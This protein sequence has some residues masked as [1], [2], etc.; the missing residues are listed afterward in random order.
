MS[1]R[2]WRDQIKS[3]LSTTLRLNTE[4]VTRSTWFL[5][6]FGGKLLQQSQVDGIQSD[7]MECECFLVPRYCFRSQQVIDV[8][9]S[10]QWSQRSNATGWNIR[11]LTRICFI[12]KQNYDEYKLD[13]F[14]HHRQ[15]SSLH[16][17]AEKSPKFVF[18]RGLWTGRIDSIVFVRWVHLHKHST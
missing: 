10:V 1:D 5:H 13:T 11:N 3:V 8:S 4:F 16:L 18:V 2:K 17:Y 12:T 7:G 15:R 14:L 6:W 9:G